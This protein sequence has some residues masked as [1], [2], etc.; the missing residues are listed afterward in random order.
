MYWASRR[1]SE[2]RNLPFQEATKVAARPALEIAAWKVLRLA[3]DFPGYFPLYSDHG[4]GSM[5][6]S[7]DQL[8][9]RLPGRPD[10]AFL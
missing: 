6:G 7:L 9:R 4:H 2:R 1:V 8:V 10:V 3:T 5:E